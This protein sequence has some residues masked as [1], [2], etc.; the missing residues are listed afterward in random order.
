MVLHK[1]L[2][3]SYCKMDR[4]DFRYADSESLPGWLVCERKLTKFTGAETAL[5]GSISFAGFG[6]QWILR[7]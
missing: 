5:D 7:N 1:V 3:I 2:G 4:K 6:T